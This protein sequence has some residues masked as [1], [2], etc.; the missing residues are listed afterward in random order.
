[1][2]PLDFLFIILTA[3]A[4]HRL[5]NYEI[6]CSRLRSWADKI[7]YLRKPLLCAAC[8]A[9]WFGAPVVLWKFAPEALHVCGIISGSYLAVRATPWIYQNITAWTT[10]PPVQ[11]PAPSP[12]QLPAQLPPPSVAKV[13]QPNLPRPNASY[14]KTVVILTALSNFHPSYSVAT[15]VLNQARAIGMQS[16]TWDV[17]V[18]VTQGA[19]ERG[20]ENMPA[21]VT[22]H[23]IVPRLNWIENQS[24][25]QASTT[26]RNFMLLYLSKLKNPSIITHDL[27]FVS[28][29]AVFARAI[30]MIGGL[31]NFTWFHVPHSLPS[32]RKGKLAHL[33]T[34][35]AGNH[36]IVSV[37]AGHDAKYAEYYDTTVDRVK[38]IP[39]IKDPRTWG[40]M[41]PRVSRLVTRLRLWDYDF[42]QI[43]PACT[44]RL[45]AK[46]FSKILQTLAYVKEHAS[47]FV[48]FC[49]PNAGGERSEKI[50]ADARAK[51]RTYGM[52]KN[53]AFVSD[54][55]PEAT[56]YG[57]D[58]P[59]IKGLMQDYGNL[60]I[61]PSMAEADSL[62]ALEA[63]LCEQYTIMNEDVPTLA[64]DCNW[65]AHY[66]ITD[67]VP[68]DTCLFVANHVLDLKSRMMTPQRIVL[69][70]RNLEGI[71]DRWRSLIAGET[72]KPR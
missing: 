54:I 72:A 7:P 24:D 23:K 70:T 11:K 27:L 41:T 43:F 15:C 37:A 49:N 8:N 12:A 36:T 30:H 38:N 14:E 50:L 6:V 42:V 60:F 44:T 35:P 31:G 55:L 62:I 33:T 32:D 56:T 53:A 5:W 65:T 2:T 26:L 61:F 22:L 46:G 18:W 20:W 29:Y 69:R 51:I 57:L 52:E 40:T 9:F 63:K 47:P 45:E 67:K 71:G 1:M 39:N 17:Q 34:L 68:L 58:A 16:P 59:E 3:A 64:A 66:G 4:L 13:P 25:E 19:D 48:L 21:N 28:W 10:K